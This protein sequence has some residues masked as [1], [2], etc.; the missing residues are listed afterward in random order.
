MDDSKDRVRRPPPQTMLYLMYTIVA[1]RA[2][3]YTISLDIDDKDTGSRS[4]SWASLVRG[5]QTAMLSGLGVRIGNS[6]PWQAKFRPR[7]LSSHHLQASHEQTSKTNGTD[8]LIRKLWSSLT[9][10][11][12]DVILM[13]TKVVK[14]SYKPRYDN[15]VLVPNTAW[16]RTRLLE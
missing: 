11:T 3:S 7:H 1:S 9:L 10:L 13:S 16:K 12:H 14:P 4:L 6:S 5:K 2:K 8:K 15:S